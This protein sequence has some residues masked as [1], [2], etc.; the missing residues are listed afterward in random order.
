MKLFDL[1][2]G[3]FQDWDDQRRSEVNAKLDKIR[4]SF[5]KNIEMMS[6]SVSG[7]AQ[8]RAKDLRL[9]LAA[10]ED[11]AAGKI[12]YKQVPRA[13]WDLVYNIPDWGRSGT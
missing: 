12:D 6:Q 5:N 8:Q 7:Y 11:F 13:A 3:E 10:L 9:E 4:M 1:V 2:E